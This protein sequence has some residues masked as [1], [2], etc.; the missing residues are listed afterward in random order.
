MSIAHLSGLGALAGQYRGF[1]VDLWG[2]IHDGVTPYDGALAC[3]R[4]LRRDGARVVL[5]SNAPRRA[6]A[7]EAGLL[8][9]GIDRT[10]FDGI[11]TSG[12]AAWRALA[13]YPGARV[14]H[15]GP[16]RDRSVLEDRDLRRVDDPRAADLLLNTG[17]DDQRDP[18]SLAAYLPELRQCLEARL[19]MLCANPDLEI[20]SA[21]RRLICA[22]ALGQWYA[23]EGGSVRWIGK[24]DPAVYELVW[25]LLAGIE[26]QRILAIGDALRTDIAGARAVGVD[27]C[28][29]LGGIH[30]LQSHSDAEAEAASAG[31]APM[32]TLD[33]LRW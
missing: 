33:G 15:L 30:A 18:A 16:P 2:V 3:L 11:A 14:Y 10:L 19:P 8:R 25:P 28:W 22:G 12:E 6:A 32:A 27:S 23:A 17:P 7:A 13:D 26:R 9:M 31:L 5:L 21:G 1:I 20:V 4:R 24:P 29:V